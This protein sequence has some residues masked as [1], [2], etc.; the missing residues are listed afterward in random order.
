MKDF[1]YFNPV[2]VRFGAGVKSELG[3]TLKDKYKK[4]LLVC[5]KGPFHENG[6]YDSVKA[7]LEENGI[8]VFEMSDVEA[9]PK[10]YRIREGVT[11]CKDNE[12]ECVIAL[13]SGS[14]IDCTKAISAAAAMHVDPYD[15]YWGKRVE[16]TRTLDTVMIPTFAATGSEMNKSSVAVNE[17]TKEKYFFD[18]DYAK[19]VFM[20][21][22][23]TLTVPIK[24]T[25]WGVMDILSHTFEYYFNG[26]R[27]SEFQTRL[28][29]AIII[30][31][32]RN[33]EKLVENPQDLNARGEIMWAAAMTWGT[34]LTWIGRGQADMACHGI[35]ESFSAYFDTHHGACLGVLTPRWMEKVAVKEKG[36]FSRFARNVMEVKEEDDEKAA[37]KGVEKYKEWVKAIGAPNTYFDLAPL[38]FSDEELLR[39]AKTACKVYH[40]GVGKMTRFGEEEVFN[41][42]KEG[43]TAY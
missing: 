17:E 4:V 42:L 1:R 40:G 11:V 5:S 21:P 41:M 38:E 13:G 23:I 35:E 7:D 14:A 32:M 39:V 25:V 24:L 8:S 27:D 16:V 19:Y 18:A 28:S 9:N 20:D 6:L 34:G 10:L 15:L 26:D 22:E 33:V 31:V 3:K 37:R 29:E 30:S 43:K 12:V 36:M 2:E